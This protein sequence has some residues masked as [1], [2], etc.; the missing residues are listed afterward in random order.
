ML[1]STADTL[2]TALWEGKGG[3][4][5]NSIITILLDPSSGVATTRIFE[6]IVSLAFD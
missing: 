2:C 4:T 1:E 3:N 5:S 6:V